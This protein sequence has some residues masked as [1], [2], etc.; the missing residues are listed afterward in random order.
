MEKD[1][2]EKIIKCRKR[3][4]KHGEVFTPRHIVNKMIDLPGLKEI[5]EELTTTVLEPSV[6]E[7]VFLVEILKR[8]LKKAK[9]QSQKDLI[10]YE[11]LSLLALTGLYGVE[12]LEDNAQKCVMNI[13]Q[14]FYDEYLNFIQEND[15]KS[16]TK[17][18]ESAKLI[19]ST[20]IVQGNFL[21]KE[22]SV[23]EP[24]VFSEWK[25]INKKRKAKNIR[26]VRTEFTLED[27]IEKVEHE[28]GNIYR[29]EEKDIQL[30]LFDDIY[31]NDD[32]DETEEKSFVYRYTEV[33]ICD[34]YKQEMEEINE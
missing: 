24:I 20:N 26:I 5:V 8:R 23:G 29:K 31:L 27:I 2:K 3:V 32:V 11:N 34:V 1:N 19:I 6:G 10:L 28:S 7:G 33:N 25:V 13:Y 9:I 12:L 21:T 16:K 18:L 30:S 4:K 22:T 15:Y 17:V 14:T